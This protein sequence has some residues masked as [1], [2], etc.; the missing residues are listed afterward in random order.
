VARDAQACRIAAKRFSVD[1]R[2]NI[3]LNIKEFFSATTSQAV[4]AQ[5][6]KNRVTRAAVRISCSRGETLAHKLSRAFDALIALLT[7]VLI[8]SRTSR[9]PRANLYGAIGI[10]RNTLPEHIA[11][12]HCRNTLPEHNEA[13][14]PT[15]HSQGTSGGVPKH[16]IGVRRASLINFESN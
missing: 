9:A 16:T 6:A 7:S 2:R 10:C 1:A 3:R 5:T 14:L 11:G 8:S 4:V 12:A 13:A 15:F